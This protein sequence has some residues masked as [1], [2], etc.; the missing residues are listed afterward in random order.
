[1]NA[2]SLYFLADC[3]ILYS[4][5]QHFVQSVEDKCNFSTQIPILNSFV[6]CKKSLETFNITRKSCFFFGNVRI[7]DF[8]RHGAV[9]VVVF[10]ALWGFGGQFEFVYCVSYTL[11]VLNLGLFSVY[12]TINFFQKFTKVFKLIKFEVKFLSI[13]W[14]QL[15]FESFL[16]KQNSFPHV[17]L[18]GAFFNKRARLLQSLII[19]VGAFINKRAQLLQSLVFLA[20]GISSIY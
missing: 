4:Y 20:S 3:S 18:V 11:E 15:L 17:F 8:L 9:F 6:N 13:T 16:F 7:G 12:P 10:V 1:M 2:D 19:L 14:N 5:L